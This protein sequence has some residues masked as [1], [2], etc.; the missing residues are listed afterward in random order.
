MNRIP[1]DGSRRIPRDQ[2]IKFLKDHGMPL[3]ELV[4]DDSYRILCIGADRKFVDQLKEQLPEKAGY[5]FET[6]N[7]GFYAGMY[8]ESFH[9]QTIVIDFALGRMESIQIA[10]NLRKNPKYD[11]ALIVGI[12]DELETKVES[13]VESGYREIFKKPVDIPHLCECVRRHA[14]R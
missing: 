13:L 4:D 9:P 6:A 1:G 11:T 8:A 14:G 10:H 7:N 5:R 12:V 2:L 3:G